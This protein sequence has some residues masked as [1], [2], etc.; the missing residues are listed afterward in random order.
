MSKIAAY[1]AALLARKAAAAGCTVEELL[2]RGE[3]EA[4]LNRRCWEIRLDRRSG[5][6]EIARKAIAHSRTWTV[7]W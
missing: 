7:I 3:V 5:W 2:R 1:K 4:E 6:P